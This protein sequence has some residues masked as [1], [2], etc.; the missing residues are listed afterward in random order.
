MP[1][2]ETRLFLIDMLLPIEKTEEYTIGEDTHYA[3]RV[4]VDR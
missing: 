1:K 2:R 3:N 4:T